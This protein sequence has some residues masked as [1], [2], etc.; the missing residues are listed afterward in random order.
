MQEFI[1]EKIIGAWQLLSWTYN[2]DKGETIHYFGENVMGIIIYD[3]SGYMN[4]QIMKA[5]RPLFSTSSLNA[6]TPEETFSAF[7][8]YLAYYGRYVENKPGELVHIIE[9]SLFPNWIGN[10]QV[11]YVSIEDD[12]LTIR[13]PPILSKDGEVVFHLAWRRVSC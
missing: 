10:G 12:R 1:K 7:S 5:S 13:T 11:R 8:G 3:R 4:A 9:G 6:G 2:N